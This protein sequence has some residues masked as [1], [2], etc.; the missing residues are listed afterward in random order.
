M[1]QHISTSF[2]EDL[3]ELD[4]MVTTIGGMAQSQLNTVLSVMDNLDEQVLNTIIKND[5]QI[6]LFEQKIF[7]KVVEIVALRSP[8]ASDLRKVMIAPRIA[9]SIERIGDLAR[10]IAKRL[11]TLKT[12]K[13]SLPFVDDFTNMGQDALS[14]LITINDAF[15]RS[16]VEK[17][18]KVWENDI[19][20]DEAYHRLT[21]IIVKT[22]DQGGQHDAETMRHCLFIAK[23]IERIGDHAT[24]IAEQIYFRVHA[25][26][27]DDNRPKQGDAEVS[28]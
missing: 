9:S 25:T 11:L 10:N 8:H 22:L 3:N 4:T 13:K 16:D 24:S 18:L 20:I 28:E 12:N 14:T 1:Q 21:E 7:D 26:Q 6:D 27:I 2:D 17:A 23:N 5:K 15:G 19:A